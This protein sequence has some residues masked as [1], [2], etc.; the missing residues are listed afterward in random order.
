[1][2]PARQRFG[3]R[4]ALEQLEKRQVDGEQENDTSE[5]APSKA[6][7]LG[8]DIGLEFGPGL[9]DARIECGDVGFELGAQPGEVVPGGDVLA[10][11]AAL[12]GDRHFDQVFLVTS[13]IGGSAG[14]SEVSE[15]LL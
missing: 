12:H 5:Q 10:E 2:L 1:M 14:V 6:G 13:R 11:P 15:V 7:L 9:G 4:A 8:G 3:A